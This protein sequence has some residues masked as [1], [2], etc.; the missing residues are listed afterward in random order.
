MLFGHHKEFMAIFNL[1]RYWCINI[2][3]R[4]F[5]YANNSIN[6]ILYNWLSAKFRNGFKRLIT[7]KCR[8]VPEKEVFKI[9]SISTKASR[10]ET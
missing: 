8:K 4:C 2:T 3:V 1:R 10:L 7:C 9:K 5:F 6:P